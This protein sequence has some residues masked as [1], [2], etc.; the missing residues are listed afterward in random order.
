MLMSMNTIKTICSRW[1]FMG[2]TSAGSRSEGSSSS[3]TKKTNDLYPTNYERDL[4]LPNHDLS[5]ENYLIRYNN[6]SMSKRRR[7][8][9][10]SMIREIIAKYRGERTMP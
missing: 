9:T 1:G 3:T 7:Y 8:E 6:Y 4:S 10:I 5:I 2:W